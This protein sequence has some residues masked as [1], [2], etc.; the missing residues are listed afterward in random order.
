[1]R[2]L[3]TLLVGA[4]SAFTILVGGIGVVGYFGYNKSRVDPV[5]QVDAIIVL[6]GEHDGREEYG[7]SLAQQG[8]ANHVILSNPYWPGDKKIAAFCASKDT[9]FTVVCIQPAP[10]TTRGEAL[11]TRKL[12][13][14]N[15]WNRVLV[16]SW[17][18]HLPR[19][20]YI[21][22]QC[23]DGEIVMRPVPR[24]YDYS[25]AEWEY[26]YLYQTVGFIKAVVQ[27]PC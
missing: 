3:V 9:R 2:K 26:T 12:V 5:Q 18:F 11:F 27:G 19:A 24:D 14:T 1:M 16:I 4:L 8:I 23:F 6:G 21:F 17:R 25:L 13:E 10:S 7:M 15:G 20:R 22:S